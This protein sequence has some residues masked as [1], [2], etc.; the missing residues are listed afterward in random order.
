MSCYKSIHI[1]VFSWLGWMQ[2]LYRSR[3]RLMIYKGGSIMIGAAK[4]KSSKIPAKS[5]VASSLPNL[6]LYM[7]LLIRNLYGF[8]I[9]FMGSS[10]TLILSYSIPE[11]HLPE[12]NYQYEGDYFTYFTFK[13]KCSLRNIIFCWCLQFIENFRFY[14]YFFQ[15]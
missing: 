10:R 3:L 7:I 9:F 6:A 8:S 5:K 15:Q 12:E 4:L 14:G 11:G 2:K 13:D 1:F